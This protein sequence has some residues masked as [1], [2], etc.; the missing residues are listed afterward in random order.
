MPASPPPVTIKR[1]RQRHPF[2]ALLKLAV[3]L[4]LLGGGLYVAKIRFLDATWQSEIEAVAEDVAERRGLEWREAVDVVTLAPNE[5]AVRLASSMLGIDSAQ[6]NAVAGEWRALGLTEGAVDLGAIGAAA[7]P[8]QP[9]FYDAADGTVYA[10]ADMSEPL[11]EL[12]LA[13]ALTN[14]LLDQ[15]HRWGDRLSAGGVPASASTRLAVR[16]LND[17]DALSIRS[18]TVAAVLADPTIAKQVSD[19]IAGMRLSAA[20]LAR[21]A[22]PYAVALASQ[23]GAAA[24]SLFSLEMTPAA[25]DRDIVEELGATNDAAVFDALRGRT[26]SAES[27]TAAAVPAPTDVPPASVAPSTAGTVSA[28]PTVPASTPTPAVTSA[29]GLVHWYYVLAGRLDADQAWRA[30]LLW[31]GDGT[32]VTATPGGMCVDAIIATSGAGE[33]DELRAAFDLWAAGAPASSATAITAEGDRNVGVHA[34]DPGPGSRTAPN[35]LIPLFGSAPDELLVASELRAAGLPPNEQAR[36]C[37]IAQLR[38]DGFPP[39]LRSTTVDSSLTHAKL[40]ITAPEVRTL[41]SSCASA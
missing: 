30:A 6:T 5:Y 8:D 35:A 10:V 12:S 17:G 18:D 37:V 9:A 19:E 16:A 7:T 41:I 32:T 24:R 25:R 20:P 15:H 28:A 39:L 21:G 11:R 38:R 27:P 13:R 31:R 22:S 2:R 34:C 29:R 3:V 1:R 14:A 40:D 4:G 33:R 36:T 26:A 23:P